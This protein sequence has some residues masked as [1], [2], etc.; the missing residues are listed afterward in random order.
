ML[1]PPL[2]VLD[3]LPGVSFVPVSIEVLG[4][5]PELDNEIVGEVFGLR[6]AAFLVPQAEQGAFVGAHNDAGV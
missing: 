6:L 2:D 5:D 3:G 1:H 4:H